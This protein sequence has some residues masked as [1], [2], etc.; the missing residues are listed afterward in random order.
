VRAVVSQF[1][2]QL[3]PD[4]KRGNLRPI[5][6]STLAPRGAVPV[7]FHARGARAETKSRAL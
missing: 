6:R 3:A 1:Q 5:L 2:M 4:C 7:S